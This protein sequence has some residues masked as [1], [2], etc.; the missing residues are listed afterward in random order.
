MRHFHFCKNSVLLLS[1]Q[2]SD[3]SRNGQL[4]GISRH[5]LTIQTPLTPLIIFFLYLLLV[6]LICLHQVSGHMGSFVAAHETLCSGTWIQWW[7]VVPMNPGFPALGAV[8]LSHWT[9]REI[10][11]PLFGS[12]YLT[13]I[14]LLQ[15][16]QV[17]S[18]R[19]TSTF[20]PNL[21]DL[22]T[23]EITPLNLTNS[24]SDNPTINTPSFTPN[25]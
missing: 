4:L 25:I 8:T 16:P 17:N 2:H 5:E 14:T 19:E 20:F 3:S 13:K 11:I 10:N 1:F 6:L 22:T 12:Y 15:S 7:H 23:L 9:T 21:T 24:K 18:Q